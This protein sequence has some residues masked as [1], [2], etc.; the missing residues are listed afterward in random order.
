MLFRSE[1][2]QVLPIGSSGQVM[3]AAA[4]AKVSF[5]AAS[6]FAE[7]ASFGPTP[8]L[9]AEI[10]A[11]GYE[12]WIDDQLALAPSQIDPKP[13]WITGNPIPRP[14]YDYQHRELQKLIMS[15]PD[16]LRARLVWSIGQFIVVGAGPHPVGVI[17]WVNMLGRQAFGNYRELL[18]TVSVNATMGEYLNNRSNRPKS[19]ECPRCA[20]NENFA[21]ELMQLFSLGV[22]QLAP[23][24]TP[25]RNSRGGFV[26][27]YKQA[28]V[29]QLARVLT[30][31]QT[32]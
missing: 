2:A 16:Q 23:D 31:W 19:V 22:Y 12:K 28:D 4:V 13:A 8:A 14:P 21:R 11:K 30:G 3:P 27:T 18:T 17:E 20:P 5:Y 1:P 32:P 9:V 15:A 26:E 24:G 7:Q 29:E 6:R 25:L 10:Q